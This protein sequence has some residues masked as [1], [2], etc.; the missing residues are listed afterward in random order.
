MCGRW[1]SPRALLLTHL[2]RSCSAQTKQQHVLQ[3]HTVQRRCTYH[4]RHGLLS[5][6]LDARAH[7]VEP[8]LRVAR[9]AAAAPATLPAAAAAAAPAAKAAACGQAKA[10]AP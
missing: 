10:A 7:V 3:A 1:R 9:S 6:R 8:A 5:A 2:E 4:R